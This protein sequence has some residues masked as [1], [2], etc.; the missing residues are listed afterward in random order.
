[1]KQFSKLINLSKFG[2]FRPPPKEGMYM[3]EI[4]FIFFHTCAK[5]DETTKFY[6]IPPSEI[7]YYGKK[8]HIRLLSVFF[9]LVILCKK[10]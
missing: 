3:I 5:M 6:L 2:A 10:S 8:G 4:F 9:R 1:M 7:A